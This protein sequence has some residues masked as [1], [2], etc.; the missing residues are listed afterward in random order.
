MPVHQ[1]DTDTARVIT[2]GKKML[3]A[4]LLKLQAPMTPTRNCRRATLPPGRKR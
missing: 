3:K 2:T 1:A 4:A